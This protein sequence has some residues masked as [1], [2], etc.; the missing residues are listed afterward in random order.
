MLITS[1][2]KAEDLME[3]DRFELGG[4]MYRIFDVQECT[5]DHFDT[6]ISFYS[7]KKVKLPTMTLIV[8][9]NTE[10]KIYNETPG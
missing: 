2:R 10:F 8:P 6:T 1:Q 7:L 5:F 4:E 9:K 3:D